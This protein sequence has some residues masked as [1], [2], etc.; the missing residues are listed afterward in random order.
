MLKPLLASWTLEQYLKTKPPCHVVTLHQNMTVG[1]ALK[2]F[3]TQNILSAPLF[4]S[5]ENEYLGFLDMT[6]LLCLLL[7]LVNVKELVEEDTSYK[8]KTAGVSLE[9]QQLRSVHH[10]N[11][12]ALIYRASL[13]STLLEV[14]EFGFLR[15][16]GGKGQCHRVAVFELEDEADEEELN[17]NSIPQG[18]HV[19]HI[20]SQTDIIQFASKRSAE[21]GPLR[22]KTLIELGLAYK[23]VVCVPAE[24]TTVKAFATMH[25]NRVSSVGIVSHAKCGALVASLSASDLRGLLP[26][27]FSALSLPVLQFLNAK[28][29]LAGYHHTKSATSN[30]WGLKGAEILKN[31]SVAT[32]T[33][34]STLEEVINILA[35]DHLHRVYVVD[36]NE[37]PVGII[38]LTDV[39]KT[40]VVD[41]QS[42]LM[43]ED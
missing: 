31:V 16:N 4:D 18:V 7:S 23:T 11:D 19:T 5:E 37:R 6:D 22:H 42:Q 28:A 24:L 33:P 34:G 26:Q 17:S 25:A 3:A 32:C 36:E 43:E 41:S 29:S 38:T 8:L 1:Q 40:L 10:N 13:H 9:Y 20:V 21:L 39:L 30:S 12:G 35:N 27:E 15:P 2:L 14:I